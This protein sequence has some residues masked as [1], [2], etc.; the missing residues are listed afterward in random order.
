MDQ[1]AHLVDLCRWFLGDFATVTGLVATFFWDIAPLEDNAFG[2]FETAAG[3]V[4]FLHASWTQWK[5]LFSF[6]V[7]GRDGYA[8]AC[9]LGGSYGREY[10][11]VGRRKV[12][13]GPP[14]EECFDFP[15]E[16]RSWALE[17]EDFIRAIASGQPPQASG[18]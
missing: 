16:D 1:G 6:E 14:E 3:Q 13:G 8:I 2:L 17:W 4:A 5:N 10:A 11:L 18:G 12:E 9:G 7:F 15:Q